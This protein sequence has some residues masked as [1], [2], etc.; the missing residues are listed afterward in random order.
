MILFNVLLLQSGDEVLNAL[1]M[2]H[3]TYKAAMTHLAWI[4]FGNLVGSWL[5][6]LWKERQQRRQFATNSD[7]FKGN[8]IPKP[9]PLPQTEKS[10]S[11]N[12]KQIN[13]PI[14]VPIVKRI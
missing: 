13:T 6:L 12:P 1:G 3:Q 10:E 4:S 14:H 11:S 5:G 7:A 8:R 2:R 9:I